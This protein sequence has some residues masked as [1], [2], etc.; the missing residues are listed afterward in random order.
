MQGR[1]FAALFTAAL[2]YPIQDSSAASVFRCVDA[3][4]HITFTRHGC[5]SEQ[6]QHLQDAR[7]HT[8]SSGKA[9]PLAAP[10]RRASGTATNPG[11][12]VIVG[13]QEDGCGNL[14]TSSERRQAIIRKEIR[15]GMS[16]ADV[17]SSLG[18]PDRV[19]A[20]NGQQRYHY[21]E[22]RKGG[23]SRQVSFDEAGCVKGK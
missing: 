18:K 13:Q 16:R 10:N 6:E 19:T 15:R 21:R 5:N 22:K 11:E 2:L 12:L 17:E 14:L 1:H 7:N 4:G 9:I 3:D 8:P 23:S 20:S